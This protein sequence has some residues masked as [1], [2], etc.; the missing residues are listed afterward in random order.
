MRGKSIWNIWTRIKW[1]K[2]W[3]NPNWTSSMG[4]NL[5]SDIFLVWS[6]F[7][8]VMAALYSRRV[9]WFTTNPSVISSSFK[10]GGHSLNF[11]FLFIF[12]RKTPKLVVVNVK[13]EY[14]GVICGS[15]DFP[16]AQFWASVVEWQGEGQSPSWTL[17]TTSSH[18]HWHRWSIDVISISSCHRVINDDHA[19]KRWFGSLL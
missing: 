19:V 6:V 8:G 16:G 2:K 14:R 7:K 9:A 12:C 4:L 1:D 13:V 11:L 10:K 17:V 3:A 15:V 5:L 18:T